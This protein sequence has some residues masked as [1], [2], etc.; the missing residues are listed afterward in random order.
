[1]LIYKVAEIRKEADGVKIFRMVPEGD[2]IKHRSGQF[3]LM[4]FLDN[5]GRSILKRPYSIASAPD[6]P[7]LEFCIKMV[8]GDFTSKLDKMKKGATVGIQ[9]PLGNMSYDGERCVFICGGTGIAPVMSMI[10]DIAKKNAK[11]KFLVFYSV[12]K[13]DLLVFR[14]ELEEL[15]KKNPSINVILT[16]TQETPEGWSGKCGRI[17]ESMLRE[18]VPDPKDFNWYLCGP[19]KMTQA[20]REC[21]LGMGVN[22]KKV[23]LEGWG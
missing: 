13:R 20:M 19:L 8:G 12:K 1:M 2:S 11:G 14:K 21:L 3:V 15:S 10:R 7:Y 6:S 5:D 18:F 17:S 9:G 16:L 4:H 22:E 23:Y